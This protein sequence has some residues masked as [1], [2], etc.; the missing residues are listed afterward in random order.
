[1][2]KPIYL[3][4][5]L[6][7]S[8]LGSVQ[9]AKTDSA[10]PDC[11]LGSLENTQS[12]N[13][14][15]FKGKVVY[16]DFWASWCGPCMQSF[17]FMNTLAHDFKDEGLQVLGINLDENI[18]DTRTFLQNTP[19]EFIVATNSTGQCAKNFGVQAMPTS[20]LVD[21]KGVIR[22]VHYGFRPNE[23]KEFRLLVEQLLA[24]PLR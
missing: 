1:M 10:A 13:L 24:E 4:V 3:L 22:H 14:Q 5:F 8:F 20:Y 23:A 17:P 19:A 6:F 21:R 9:A 12:F 11:M 18:E 7:M 15:R 2:M 16:V